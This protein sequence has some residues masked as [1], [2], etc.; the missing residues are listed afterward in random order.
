MCVS[1]CYSAG[2][3]KEGRGLTWLR[4]HTELLKTW[5]GEQMYFHDVFKY[6]EGSRPHTNKP[7][8]G[9]KCMYYTVTLFAGSKTG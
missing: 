9:S 7:C 5:S 2:R 6:T 1:R 3:Y 8:K 4:L